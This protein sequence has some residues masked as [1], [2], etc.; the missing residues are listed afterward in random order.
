MSLCPPTTNDP[1]L[2]SLNASCHCAHIDPQVVSS[3]IRQSLPPDFDTS[4]LENLIAETAVFLAQS[5]YVQM[6]RQIV[7]IERIAG[8]DSYRRLVAQRAP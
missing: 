3:Q 1:G 6:Q 2:L 7:A 8:L 4:Q 5:D